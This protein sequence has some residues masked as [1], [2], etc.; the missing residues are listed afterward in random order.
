MVKKVKKVI[1]VKRKK[2][3]GFKKNC[4]FCSKKKVD[5]DYKNIDFIAR[6]ISSKKKI[7]SRRSSGNCA[8]HQ[9]KVVKEIKR[10]KSL[11][12]SHHLLSVGLRL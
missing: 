8:K 2:E 6:F 4:I 7:V 12:Q 10:A 9:R 5:I 1:R 3:I 11:L